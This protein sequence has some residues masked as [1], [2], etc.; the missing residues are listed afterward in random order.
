MF[1]K[2]PSAV[3]GPADAILLPPTDRPVHHE[4]E[5][6]MVMGKRARGVKLEEAL[7][8]VF[9]YTCGLDITVRGPQDRSQRKSYDTFA[10]V[11]P[12]L[13]TA[14][15]IPDPTVLEITLWVNGQQRQHAFTKDMV[16]DCPHLIADMSAVATMEPGDLVF[17]GTP[18]GVGPLV[19]GDLVSIRITRV[20]DMALRVE[21]RAY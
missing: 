2:A 5:L 19:P 8:Y 17:T 15:E 11:G 12:H 21:K 6:V 7:Q 18:E 14:D 3:A 16:V 10:P 9:G 20:G 4:P 13:V 1:L